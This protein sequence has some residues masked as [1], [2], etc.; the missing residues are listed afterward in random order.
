MTDVDELATAVRDDPSG[1]NLFRLWQAVYDLE[2]WWLL[3]TGEAA[4]P[5]PMVGVVEDQT[6][7]LAF[8]SDRHVKDFASRQGG[9]VDDSGIPAMSVTPEDLT[10]M[11]TTLV[12]QG[13]A[14]ILFDQG[15]HSFLAPATALEDLWSQ[16]GRPKQ[17]T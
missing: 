12:G 16:F 6:F 13:V 9:P 2:Q 1:E 11:S 17:T 10:G 3:P 4:D 15:V 5:R 8:T 14:G 7:L